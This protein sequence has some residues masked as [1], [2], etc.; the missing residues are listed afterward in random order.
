MCWRNTLGGPRRGLGE[1]W[2]RAGVTLWPAVLH[3]HPRASVAASPPQS[4]VRTQRVRVCVLRVSRPRR[5]QE[6]RAKGTWGRRSGGERRQWRPPSPHA[7]GQR[8][9]ENSVCVIVRGCDVRVLV[10]VPG[11]SQRGRRPSQQPQP[12]AWHNTPLVALPHALT[13]AA[14]ILIPDYHS[15]RRDD[16][17]DHMP[18]TT[19]TAAAEGR[20]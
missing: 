16:R 13:H 3:I 12:P 5:R 10:V 8:G 1:G 4:G 7:G 20:V 19:A 9:A 2:R 6:R 14:T 11:A 18:R 15:R 17:H